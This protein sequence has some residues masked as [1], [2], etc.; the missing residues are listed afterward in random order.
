[1]PKAGAKLD[2]GALVG[3]VGSAFVSAGTGGGNESNA[4][5]FRNTL[6]H[7]GMVIVGLPY[8]CPPLDRPLRREGWLALWRRHHRGPGRLAP[9]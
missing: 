1:L 8:S 5:S 4:L 2:Q 9:A 7:H 3:K 6:L